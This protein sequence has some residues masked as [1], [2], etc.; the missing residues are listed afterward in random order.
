MNGKGRGLQ[1]RKKCCLGTRCDESPL[2]PPLFFN[3]VARAF[4]WVWLSEGIE[5]VDLLV[6][7]RDWESVMGRDFGVFGGFLSTRLELGLIG[8]FLSEER[9]KPAQPETPDKTHRACGFSLLLSLQHALLA[10]SPSSPS[11]DPRLSL[12]RLN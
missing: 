8:A 2:A 12:E 5:G 7:V 4:D 3:V 9:V 1:G 11:P 6:A 10:P